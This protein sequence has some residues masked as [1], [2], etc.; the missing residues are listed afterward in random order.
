MHCAVVLAGGA[1]RRMGQDKALLDLGGELAITRVVEA[2]TGAGVDVIWIVRFAAAEALPPDAIGPARVVELAK[3]G[4]MLD[5]VRLGLAQ[6][7]SAAR[8][9]LVFPVD[10]AMVEADVVAAV[11]GGLDEP[12]ASISLPLWEERPGHPIALAREIMAEVGEPGVR[13][14]RDVIGRDRARVHAVPVGSPWVRR[15]LDTPEDLDAA[16][17]WLAAR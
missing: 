1:G 17:A 2:C 10:Y 13:T 11:L 9:A 8:S 6:V 3:R 14:L 16:R 7:S 15:D 5:S 4:E 12:K